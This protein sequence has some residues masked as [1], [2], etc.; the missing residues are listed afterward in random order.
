[1]VWGYK[2]SG[3]PK[4]LSCILDGYRRWADANA[5][6]STTANHTGRS[7]RKWAL[8]TLA[9]SWLELDIPQKYSNRTLAVATGRSG[10][11]RLGRTAA[12][13]NQ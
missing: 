2:R 3:D 4:T 8:A 13:K 1:M 6:M 7:M 12:G 10:G 5:L 9:T 11:E